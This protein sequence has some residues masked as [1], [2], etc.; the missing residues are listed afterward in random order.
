MNFKTGVFF[1]LLLARA[2]FGFSQA[3]KVTVDDLGW[4][5]G[6]WASGGG[7]EISEQWMRPAGRMMLGMSRTVAGGETVEFEFIQI[8]ETEGG[9][10]SFI[11]KPSGQ[12]SAAFRLVKSGRREAVFE[13][14][15][16]DFPQRIIYRLGDDGT[17]LA[18]I[19]GLSK[20]RERAVDYPLKR[21]SC[22]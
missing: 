12:E 5:A 9:G 11:A 4:L 20:G 19:E 1:L 8:R 21:T 13:N 7:R 17:L 6:C 15:D 16:H 3:G 10:I 14:L 22:H 2:C 18:R